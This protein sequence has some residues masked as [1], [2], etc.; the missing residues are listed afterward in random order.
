MIY[1]RVKEHTE[2]EEETLYA[3][4]RIFKNLVLITYFFRA[5]M[6]DSGH[7]KAVEEVAAVRD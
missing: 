5:R 7:L 2:L 1:L 4:L 6:D 3:H